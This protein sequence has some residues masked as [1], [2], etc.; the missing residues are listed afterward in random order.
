MRRSDI[1]PIVVELPDA[2]FIAVDP[3]GLN[4]I[5]ASPSG[6]QLYKHKGY[7]LMYSASAQNLYVAPTRQEA[8]R[9]CV[10]SGFPPAKIIREFNIQELAG[11]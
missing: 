10:R 9:W 6:D 1:N 2:T 7:Y 5:M 8:I 11:S 3:N 4:A